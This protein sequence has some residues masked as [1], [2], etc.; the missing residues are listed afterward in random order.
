MSG[1]RNALEVDGKDCGARSYV[2]AKIE[3][4]CCQWVLPVAVPA[5]PELP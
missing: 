3:P 4:C 1:G 5:Q 2:Y